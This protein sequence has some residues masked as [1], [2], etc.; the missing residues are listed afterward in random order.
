MPFARTIRL[1][2]GPC[3]GDLWDPRSEPAQ[4]L[5]IE[6]VQSGR[7]KKFVE[8]A[9]TQ[10]G[11][12]LKGVILPALYA[13]CELGTSVGYVMP[14]LDKLSQKWTG[15]LRPMIESAGFLDWFPVN[16]PGSKG[17]RPAMLQLRHPLTNAR[18]GKLYFMAM[19]G[20]GSETATASNPCE[21]VVGDEA[22]DADGVGQLMLVLKRAES[23]GAGG[24]AFI[25]G[26]VNDRVGRDVHPILELHSQGTRT[27]V[28]HQCPHCRVHVVP[29]FEDFD[30]R[31]A[32]ITCPECKT[33]WSEDDRHAALDA[34]IYKHADPGAEIFSVLT[35]GLDYHWEIPD[36]RT[37]EVKLLLPSIA[38]ELRMA[39][40]AE[41]RDQSIMRQH[42]MKVWCRDWKVANVNQPEATTA[43]LLDIA[44]K[45][46]Y[47]R[48]EVPDGVDVLHLA[49]DVQLRELYWITLGSNETDWWVIDWGA[50]AVCDQLH[51]PSESERIESL[52]AVADM[53]LQGWPRMGGTG[54]VPVQMAGVDAGF[55]SDEVR[56]WVAKRRQ[57]WVSIKG[58]GQELA[59]RMRS[60]QAAPGERQSHE[61]RWY[62]VRA[63]D[64]AP[65]RRQLFPSKHDILDRI[66]EDWLAGRG[67]LPRDADSQLLHHLTGYQ[68]NPK[69]TGER[70]I[71]RGKRHDW[72]DGLVYCRA[73]WRW[74]RNIRKP[75][76][77]QGAD[78]QSA[79]NGVAAA[80]RTHRY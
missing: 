36:R 77:D 52:D 32:V 4:R 65:D 29:D 48:G 69:A 22:D 46:E 73:L 24:R 45:A 68:R 70:W 39:M 55:K 9:P 16:G 59:H 47:Q 3:K 31:S 6:E 51:Q 60:V 75:D 35:T 11:K 78:L 12:T 15:T 34:A 2:D 49:T 26:T 62:E 1:P 19:G 37:G 5:F 28:A 67:H 80:R 74:R 50:H 25:I 43:H 17:G 40:D 41:D 27:R 7:R 44:A 23:Y 72:F 38:A 58:A 63:Q 54:Q 66:A 8:T 76:S 30:V 42:M 33:P 56:P 53:A 21:W 64:D 10:R 20:G 71:F 57:S 14:T 18:A 79:L 61:E 13:A